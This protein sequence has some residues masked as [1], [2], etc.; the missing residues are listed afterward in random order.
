MDSLKCRAKL[1]TRS[2]AS[3]GQGHT[4]RLPSRPA[5]K[6]KAGCR[7]KAAAH[8]GNAG[9]IQQDPDSQDGLQAAL[10]TLLGAAV[11]ASAGSLVAQPA[12][13]YTADG[14]QTNRDWKPR[15]HHRRLD[16][17]QRTVDLGVR[18][19]AGKACK[20]GKCCAR[21]KDSTTSNVLAHRKERLLCL[22]S[23][24]RLLKIR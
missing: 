24:G 17:R 1:S 4:E 9:T 15:R 8:R 19:K 18:S 21:A 10:K 6:Y 22:S 3:S 12:S 11:I 20:A 2:V 16:D 14:S 7:L 23:S 13:A 5:V